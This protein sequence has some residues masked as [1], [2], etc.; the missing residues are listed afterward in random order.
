VVLVRQKG[1]PEKWYGIVSGFLERGESPE[2]GILRE[3]EEE[4]G[5]QGEIVRFIGTYSFFQLNQL[6]LAYHV[7][8]EGDI[9]LGEELEAFKLISPGHLRPWEMGRTIGAGQLEMRKIK[10]NGLRDRSGDRPGKHT[11]ENYASLQ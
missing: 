6:I 11:G 4:L 9:Q 2:Q 1:W 5:V 3:V 8:A 7:R 10:V